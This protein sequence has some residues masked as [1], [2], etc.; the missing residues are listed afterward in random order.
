MQGGKKLL[1]EKI[2]EMYQKGYSFERLAEEYKY[3]RLRYGDHYNVYGNKKKF[4]KKQALR[5]VYRII[6]KWWKENVK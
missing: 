6:Q 5:E 3:L 4:E 1:E 2:I